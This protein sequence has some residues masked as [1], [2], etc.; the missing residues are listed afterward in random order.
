MV[1][2]IIILGA[3]GFIGS[4]LMKNF[5]ADRTY[6]V[7][8]YS[9]KECDL[10]SSDS[11]NKALSYVTSDDVIIMASSITRQKDDS[12]ESMIKNIKMAENVSRFLGEHKIAQLIFI[13]S[14]DV[15]GS[16]E[17]GVQISESSALSPNT[18]YGISKLS[19]EFILKNCC[20]KNKIPLLI[21]RFPGIYGPDDK[22]KSTVA[23]FVNSAI[24]GKVTIFGD[25]KD[26]RDFVYVD[27][28]YRLIKIAI[29]K[30]VSATLNVATGKSYSLIEIAETIKLCVSNDFIVKY[31]PKEKGG[32]K[33]VKELV[34]DTGLLNKFFPNF[35]FTTL[36]Q[37]ISLYIKRLN[38]MG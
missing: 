6:D 12:F 14:V 15:Y 1:K 26:K 32:A 9:S 17:T 5:S 10:L 7:K 20:S 8:G 28:V 38:L 35:K 30:E 25:G 4:Y 34:Y 23:Q 13:S 11:M 33:R 37:G 21:L 27:D 2:K 24:K 19:S 18:Y 16:V 3:S 36:K 29:D 31:K 22:G